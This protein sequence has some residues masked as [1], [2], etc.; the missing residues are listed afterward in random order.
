MP[1]P[2]CWQQ[3]NPVHIICGSG[4][5]KQLAKHL[6]VAGRVLLVTSEG[7]VRR[8]EAQALIQ[9][10]M[11]VEWTVQTITPNPDLDQLDDIHTKLHPQAWV[12][13]V[14]LGGG[15]VIDAAKTL[16]LALQSPHSR[17]LQ[18]WLREGKLDLPEPLPL[19]CL[20]T[21]AGTGAEVTPFATVWDGARQ[22]KCS[23]GGSGLFPAVALL[24]PELTLS[25][26][27]QETLFTALDTTSHA[28]ETLWNRHATP[29]SKAM[30]VEALRLLD[31]LLPR[32]EHGLSDL[33]MRE[34]LQTAS[35]FAGL[36]ISQSR[37]ALAH[38]ISYPLTL[39]YAVPHGLACSFTLP[40][41]I[42]HVQAAQAFPNAT[43][44]P[45]LQRIEKALRQFELHKLLHCYCSTEDVLKHIDEMFDPARADNFVLEVE[46]SLVKKL[47]LVSC[48]GYKGSESASLEW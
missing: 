12:A 31:P 42:R 45:L 2:Q 20:P 28:L 21:T 34:Q 4:S 25:L 6:P 26:P 27:W 46:G 39:H 13:V 36:A 33:A 11:G 1:E 47:L 16:A 22:K 30:A 18:L 35:L 9:N 14:A 19:V 5:R 38:A 23:L 8:G 32:L 43:P 48:D 17:P 41:L 40:A 44:V 37:T 10:C 3:H 7:M 24:D 29:V 15:S